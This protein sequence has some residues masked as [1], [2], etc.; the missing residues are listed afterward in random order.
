M[1]TFLTRVSVALATVGLAGGAALGVSGSAYAASGSVEHARSSHVAV[2]TGS[3]RDAHLGAGYGLGH[4]GERDDGRHQH[5]RHFRGAGHHQW[6]RVE[7]RWIDVTLLR[8]A[9]AGSWYV[10]QVLLAQG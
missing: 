8:N 10:D 3:G 6:V 4:Y 7:G 9:G 5:R 1:K 2:E